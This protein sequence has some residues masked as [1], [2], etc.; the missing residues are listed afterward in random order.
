MKYIKKTLQIWYAE[1]MLVLHN[2]GLVIFCLLVPLAYPLLYAFVYTNETVREV[3]IVVVDE[4]HSQQSREFSRKV[5]ACSEVT[6]MYHTDLMQAQELL[7]QEKAYAIMRIPSS[8]SQDLAE[9]RQTYVA[10]YSD[11]RCMLYYKAA[12]LAASNVSLEMNNDIKVTRYLRGSTDRQE[13]VLRQPVTNSYVALYN[14]Q[15]GVASFLIPAVMMLMIQQLLCLTIG[16]SMGIV[17]EKNRGIGIP[18]GNPVYNNPVSIIA[19]KVLLYW[20]IF[21]LIGV[22]M[23]AG[24]TSL[25]Q[26]PQLG[27]Y[28]TFLR[29]MVPYVL[30]C[31]L[32]SFTFST[33][34]H[35]A[36][37]SMLLFIFMS[38]PLLFVSGMSWPVASEPTFWRYVSYIFPSTFGMH[39]YVRIQ[40]MGADLQDVGFEYRGLWMQCIVYFLLSLW[41]Y[42]AELVRVVRWNKQEE[43]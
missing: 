38:V 11:M 4:C 34:I 2:Q 31:I 18:L 6:V 22:Y 24:V 14:P 13:A 17:R 27:D 41:V 37:D 28:V 12:L 25:F 21:M 26:M 8:F 9:G 23:F 40:N 32:M 3:P 33:F 36:E 39:G 35:R 43:D 7:R 29:F 30:A 19:G 5:D 16:T 10:L 42:R 20:P 15:S 1:L